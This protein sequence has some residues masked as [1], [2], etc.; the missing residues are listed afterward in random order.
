[1]YAFVQ[2][3]TLPARTV[4]LGVRTSARVHEVAVV[5][6]W[7]VTT[8]RVAAPARPRTKRTGWTSPSSS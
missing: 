5:R 6:V 3:T 8:S 7:I 1:V 4:A 2:R